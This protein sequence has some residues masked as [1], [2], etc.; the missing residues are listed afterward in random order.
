M[1]RYEVKVWV[2]LQFEDAVEMANIETPREVESHMKIY[3][4]NLLLH[5]IHG[6]NIALNVEVEAKEGV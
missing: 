2:G 4:E 6:N 5:A 1:K 3:V